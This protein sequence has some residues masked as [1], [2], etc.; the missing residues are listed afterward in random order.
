MSVRKLLRCYISSKVIRLIT[1]LDFGC[2]PGRDLKAFAEL[3]HVAIGLEGAS[4]APLAVHESGYGP[5]R[6][7]RDWG[8]MTEFGGKS[9]RA[10]VDLNHAMQLFEL[11]DGDVPGRP[12]SRFAKAG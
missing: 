7:F 9:D 8:L 12:P 11:G 10:V 2:G 3:G 5:K 6:T 4:H 1:I